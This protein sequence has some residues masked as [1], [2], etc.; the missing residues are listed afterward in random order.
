MKYGFR[1]YRPEP[2]E[3]QHNTAPPPPSDVT[4]PMDPLEEIRGEVER[5]LEDPALDKMTS[6]RVLSCSIEWRH[7]LDM[8]ATRG[9]RYW[10]TRN[11]L[12]MT[13][14]QGELDRM[15]RRQTTIEAFRICPEHVPFTMMKHWTKRTTKIQRT[16]LRVVKKDLINVANGAYVKLHE[17]LT[18]AS[19]CNGVALHVVL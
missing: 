2:H 18:S 17:H 4:I 1:I 3:S 14:M 9:S 11:D 5:I 15:V 7:S 8:S 10:E 13:R 6:I 19:F 16:N 12:E